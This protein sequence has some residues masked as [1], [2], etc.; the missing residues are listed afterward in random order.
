MRQNVCSS[1]QCYFG[2]RL[3]N[4]TDRDEHVTD[5]G[6][7]EESLALLVLDE[8]VRHEDE[9]HLTVLHCHGNLL[10]AQLTQVVGEPAA[11]DTPNQP[12]D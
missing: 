7:L 2:Y 5:L 8:L 10:D 9:D 11:I 6:E 12:Y 4:V 1:R 3:K